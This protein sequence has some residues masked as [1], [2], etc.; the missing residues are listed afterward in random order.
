MGNGGGD[1]EA[2]KAAGWTMAVAGGVFGV[3][4]VFDHFAE[5]KR[6][7]LE[8]ELVTR[9]ALEQ[10][11]LERAERLRAERERAELEAEL[12]EAERQ[13]AE[14]ETKLKR[15]AQERAE[16]TRRAEPHRRRAVRSPQPASA[17]RRTWPAPSSAPDGE[18]YD[19]MYK[20]MRNVKD[21][22]ERD[23]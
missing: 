13:R 8:L 1:D 3:I 12:E 16:R 19:W 5:R 6:R 20:L 23:E 4:K 15:A 18:N 14:L 17:S 21:D 22:L 7:A 11:E 2:L 10:A 9:A